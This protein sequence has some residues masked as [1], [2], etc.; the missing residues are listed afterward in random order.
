[1]F[2]D[3]PGRDLSTSFSYLHPSAYNLNDEFEAYV[4]QRLKDGVLQMNFLP[5]NYRYD[6]QSLFLLCALF[7]I[8]SV[9]IGKL[10]TCMCNF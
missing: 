1:M 3:T 9:R 7:L 10:G 4:V 5:F 6:S 8:A 2:R